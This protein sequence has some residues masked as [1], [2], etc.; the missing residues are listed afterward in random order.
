VRFSCDS[1]REYVKTSK[2]WDLR[3]FRDIYEDVGADEDRENRMTAG[4]AAVLPEGGAA[5][6]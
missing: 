5:G 4:L 1:Y 2:T 6:G 3:R